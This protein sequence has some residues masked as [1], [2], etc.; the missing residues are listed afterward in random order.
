MCEGTGLCI[1][2]E[3]RNGRSFFL[4]GVEPLTIRMEREM[5][6]AVARRKANERGCRRRQLTGCVIE[7]V[8]VDPILPEVGKQNESILRIR[9][10]HVRMRH[11]MP[12]YGE[13]AGRGGGCLFRSKRAGI[14]VDKI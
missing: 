14:L 7:L 3:K 5:P 6:G 10:D 11:I 2:V 12:T 1:V 8:D 13:A 9:L 4:N